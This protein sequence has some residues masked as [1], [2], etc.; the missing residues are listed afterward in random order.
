MIRTTS[1]ILATIGIVW[2]LT[3]FMGLFIPFAAI[4]TVLIGERLGA[5]EAVLL[6]VS[7]Q[8][9]FGYFIWIGWAFRA[10]DK[11]FLIPRR[12]FWII[13]AIHHLLWFICFLI[14]YDPDHIYRSKGIEQILFSYL[15]FALVDSTVCI[16]SDRD[17]D[18]AEHVGDGKARSR[19]GEKRNKGTGK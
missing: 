1:G 19:F 10:C 2:A 5:I 13:S 12:T 7:F 16:F 15:G 17:D 14:D 3:A 4:A 18:D 11:R 8:V 6:F 9:Y